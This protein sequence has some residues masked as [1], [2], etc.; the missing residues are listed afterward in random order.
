MKFY[1]LIV[2]GCI[3][4]LTSYTFAQQPVYKD[5]RQPVTKRV[6]DLLS[7]MTLEEKVAQLQTMHAGRPK[8]N[9][10]LFNNAARMDSLFKNGMGM[11]N[12]AFD[13]TME[14]TIYARNKLQDYCKNKTRLGI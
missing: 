7:R 5:A 2:M 3:C 1:T 10:Q 11:M 12:P 4:C 13:E 8:L 9:D 6:H 14:Q